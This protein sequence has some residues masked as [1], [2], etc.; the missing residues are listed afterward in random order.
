MIPRPLLPLLLLTVAAQAVPEHPKPAVEEAFP[1]MP[2]VKALSVAESLNSMQ[3]P[4]GYRLEPVLTDPEIREP[5]ALSFDGDGRM[6][7]VEMRTYMQDADGTGEHDPISRVSLHEDSDGDGVYDKHTVFADN[8]LLPRM[9][10]PL[11]K[12][13]AVIGET[14]TLDLY[15]WTDTDGDGKADKKELFFEGGPRGGNMEHQPSGLMWSTDN[16][17]Y[18]TYNAFRLRWTPE[19]VVKEPTAPNGGQWGV[20]QDDWARQWYVNAGGEK[21][22]VNFQTPIVYGAFSAPGQFATG[23]DIVWPAAIGIPDVQGGD[24]RFRPEDKTLNHFTATCGGEIY[25]GDR[26]PAELRGDLFFGE[27]VG[28]LARRAKITQTDGLTYLSNPY[29]GSEFLRSTDPLFRPI[30]FANAPDGTLY[31]IDMHRGIIQEGNWVKEGSYLRKVVLQYGLDKPVAM[32]RL[33]RLV[34]ETT[35]RGPQPKMSAETPA[36]LVAHLAH[37]NGWWRDTAQKLLILKQDKSVVPALTAM[38]RKDGSPLARLHALWTLEG[39]EAL[40][41]ELVREKLNDAHPQLRVAAIRVSESFH[42][43]EDKSLV[44]DVQAMTKDTDPNVVIQAVLTAKRLDMPDWKKSLETLVASSASVGVKE[45]GNQILNPPKAAPKPI[46]TKDEEK[47]YKAGE[48]VFQTLCSACHGIDGKGMPMLGAT[49]GAMLAPALAG[50]KTVTGWRD[51]GIHVLLQ[52][53]SGDIDGKRYEGQMIPMATNDD[54]WIAGVLSY[55][56]NSFGNRAGFVSPSEV[57][58]IRAATKDRVQPWTIDEL[59]A[60]LPQPLA[61]RK[62]WKLTASHAPADAALAV[63]GKTETRYTTKTSMVPGMWFQIEL[64]AETTISGLEIEANKSPGDYPRSY[65]VELST[66][67]QTWGKP[68]AAGKGNAPDLAVQFPAAKTKFIRITQTGEMKGKFWSI[69]ELQV[70]APSPAQTVGQR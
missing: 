7:V 15:L 44:P 9:V 1:P 24:R 21:G 63:D 30:Q 38:A 54:D 56:R 6:F 22:P 50:S 55:V 32:G 33:Y 43:A 10:L 37:P 11:E 67:G 8:L 5:V 57:A 17:I 2:P 19:G 51:A 52:G 45:I 29:E 13:K 68:V 58:R 31:L 40:T 3:L 64:P 12:G 62:D 20:S 42:K 70:F 25:R 47:L 69:H 61:N 36:Q 16:W 27:P 39:L 41:P 66:D 14:D 4:P 34:H 59:R 28:R 48:M 26:L 49:P 23:F 53:L 65:T 46:M 35:K 60:K 18:T